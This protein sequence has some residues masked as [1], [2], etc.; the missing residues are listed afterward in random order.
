MR[1][2]T[3]NI[4][5]LLQVTIPVLNPLML[6]V[7]GISLLRTCGGHGKVFFF[8]DPPNFTI[9]R[10]PC[11][12]RPTITEYSPSIPIPT[13]P[14]KAED[15]PSEP[16]ELRTIIGCKPLVNYSLSSNVTLRS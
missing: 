11:S 9:H 6:Q 14:T 12:L 16:S 15:M 1:K 4:R 7:T 8:S 13:H 5:V 10:T 3:F 2:L